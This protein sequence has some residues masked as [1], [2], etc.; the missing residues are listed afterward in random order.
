MNSDR[1]P[2]KNNYKTNKTW[3]QKLQPF[4]KSTVGFLVT[5]ILFWTVQV[6][7][8]AYKVFVYEP[9]N[10]S[11]KVAEETQSLQEEEETQI[12][13]ED[14]EQNNLNTNE[15][16]TVIDGNNKEID[17][18]R[19][20][21]GI[22]IFSENHRNVQARGED[23][24][25]E[26]SLEP[27]LENVEVNIENSETPEGF[28]NEEYNRILDYYERYRQNVKNDLNN[29]A[30]PFVEE[31]FNKGFGQKDLSEVSNSF[32]E[33]EI[34][35]YESLVQLWSNHFDINLN[36]STAIMYMSTL[37]DLKGYYADLEK[38]EEKL[39]NLMKIEKASA[40]NLYVYDMP[41]QSIDTFNLVYHGEE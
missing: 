4:L 19:F 28:R 20:P 26:N 15:T 5:F 37:K 3:R 33:K 23:L 41:P 27:A 38:T 10:T 6:G 39:I 16:N 40:S 30:D 17:E 11:T 35:A 13:Q 34:E 7:E 22:D 24:H 32:T 31:L 1:L 21:S 14:H 8:V 9:E 2:Y 36:N 18:M 25:T 12:T 29:P